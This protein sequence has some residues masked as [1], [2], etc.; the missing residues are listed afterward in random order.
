MRSIVTTAVLS[1][2]VSLLTAA[3]P[4]YAQGLDEGRLDP[5]WFSSESL[6]FRGTEEI[7]YLWVRDGYDFS[8][9]TLHF[10]AWPEP[11]DFVGPKAQD[12][13][14]NDHRLAR[15]MSAE[16]AR[17]FADTLNRNF[18]SQLPSSNESGEILVEGRIADCST[19]STAAKALVGFGAGAGSTTID[20]KFV[21]KKSGKLVAA[22]HQR[23]VSGTNWSTTDSK[24]FKWMK[25]FGREVSK[26]GWGPAYA[27]GKRRKE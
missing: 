13:D 17:S 3:V 25:K 15:Q 8:G 21:D 26:Q 19:G 2:A 24:F 5:G 14:E 11:R 12:R 4:L 1:L 7:D 23:V 9:K 22:I 20:M 10:Q 27:K 6:E 16:M 18:G